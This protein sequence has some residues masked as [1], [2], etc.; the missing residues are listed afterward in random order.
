TIVGGIFR[1]LTQL[2]DNQAEAVRWFEMAAA[3][4]FALAEMNLGIMFLEG[5][6]VPRDLT[7][8][9]FWFQKAAK[10]GQSAAQFEL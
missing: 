8:A 7:T 10:N 2:P 9:R 1:E 5:H 3:Q 6:G 4:D